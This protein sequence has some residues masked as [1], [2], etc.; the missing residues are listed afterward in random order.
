MKNVFVFSSAFVT[1][2]LIQYIDYL[3]NFEIGEI[4]VLQENHSEKEFQLPNK[5]IMVYNN[6]VE[7]INNCDVVIVIDQG[8]I[9][10]SSL[11]F[12]NN[13]S[14]RSNKIVLKL[15]S[16]WT[17][18]FVIHNNTAIDIDYKTTP[19]ILN[20]GVGDISEQFNTEIILNKIFASK[21][22]RFYQEYSDPTRFFLHQLADNNVLNT[23]LNNF[24]F[25]KE[26]LVD[27][28]IKSVTI[29][30]VTDV[31]NI[32]EFI[33]DISPDYVVFSTGYNFAE[34]EVKKIFLYKFNCHVFFIRSKYIEI[35]RSE[36]DMMYIY[37]NKVDENFCYME[38]PDAVEK[39]ELDMLSRI[40]YPESIYPVNSYLEV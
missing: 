31:I 6:L 21:S 10:Q 9:P 28:V 26:N 13:Y 2:M 3:T 12:I 25:K 8:R 1:R 18:G 34:D 39:L 37:I 7:C 17:N 36:K 24:L 32:S 38:D 23:N 4:I 27:V 22:I 35:N 15:T 11:E 16:P 5:R 33:G 19:V 14:E 29:S 40:A 20:I 30:N